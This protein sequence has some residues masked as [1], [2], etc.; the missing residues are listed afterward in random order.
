MADVEHQAFEVQKQQLLFRVNHAIKL[1]SK[2]HETKIKLGKLRSIADRSLNIKRGDAEV[3]V[4]LGQVETELFRK[5][6]DLEEN[7][8]TEMEGIT[9][10]LQNFEMTAEAPGNQSNLDWREISLTQLKQEIEH[11][12]VDAMSSSSDHEIPGYGLGKRSLSPVSSIFVRPTTAV[13]AQLE[14]TTH[15]RNTSPESSIFVRP[16]SQVED[17]QRSTQTERCESPTSSIFVQSRHKPPHMQ[18]SAIQHDDTFSLLSMESSR[19][20]TPREQYLPTVTPTDASSMRSSASSLILVN[21]KAETVDKSSIEETVASIT[22][23]MEER[24]LARAVVEQNAASIC[25]YR[26][27]TGL[28]HYTVSELMQ[29]RRGSC[30]AADTYEDPNSPR[31]GPTFSTGTKDMNSPR[32]QFSGC[33]NNGIYSPRSQNSGLSGRSAVTSSTTSGHLIARPIP[34]RPPRSYSLGQQSMPRAPQPS[35]AARSENGDRSNNQDFDMVTGFIFDKDDAMSDSSR[36]DRGVKLAE[37]HGFVFK[38]PAQARSMLRPQS[39]SSAKPPLP[40]RWTP[41]GR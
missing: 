1:K 2:V 9:S 4:K 25:D 38:N 5:M 3:R 8:D 13:Q 40:P 32:S 7:L 24:G 21:N 18:D 29:Q 39:T 30:F 15:T 17:G 11:V 26:A 37:A 12:L 27:T 19:T 41:H 33:L 10:L 23:R 14:T 35:M 20:I 36:I 28:I 6:H 31:N 34:Q 16:C 22:K